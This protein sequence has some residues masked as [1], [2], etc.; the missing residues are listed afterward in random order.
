MMTQCTMLDKRT[1][2]DG[3]FGFTT[4][5]VDGATFQATIIKASS[6]EARVAE[7]QGVSEV[8]TVVAAKGTALQYHDVFR[9]ESDGQIFRVTSLQRDSEAPEAS[10][11][12]IGKVSAE[13]WELPQ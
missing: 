7:A 3:V 1:V 8:Y 11:V 9:R 5:Y 4:A 10:T 6:I 2:S 12:Q 13:R